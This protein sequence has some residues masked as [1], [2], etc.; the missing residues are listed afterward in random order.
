M[1]TY[2]YHC[3]KCDRSFEFTQSMK[4]DALKICPK[5]VCQR[6]TWGR[7]TVKRQ[8][9]T[10]AGL[11]FKGTGFYVTDYRSD[12]YKAAERSDSKS[13]ETAKTEAKTETKTE[14]KPATT[15]KTTTPKTPSK[16]D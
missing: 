12:K 5:G 16:T 2:E 3:E 4:D 14:S 13:G 6:K 11:I 1:P 9:G 15:E 10:G 8:I 7:G